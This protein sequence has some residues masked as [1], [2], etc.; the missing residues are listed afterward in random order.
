MALSNPTV[1]IELSG[2]PPK[3][4]PDYSSRFDLSR[5]AQ[6][7]IFGTDWPGVPGVR[8]NAAAVL[9]LGFDDLTQARIL[10][11]NAVAVYGGLDHLDPGEQH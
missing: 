10:G 4:L 1:W 8:A 9:G 3:R 5:L 6:K 2:L 11:H 7:W